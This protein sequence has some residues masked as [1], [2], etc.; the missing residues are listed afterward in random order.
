MTMLVK[1]NDLESSLSA[2]LA[3]ETHGFD[4]NL[5]VSYHICGKLGHITAWIESRN[6]PIHYNSY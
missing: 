5:R 4:S 1:I 3:K 2:V 6:F